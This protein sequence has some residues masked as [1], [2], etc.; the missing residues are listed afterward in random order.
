MSLVMSEY[1]R[2]KFL[3]FLNLTNEEQIPEHIKKAYFK[4]EKTGNSGNI[5]N[6]TTR[7]I[8]FIIQIADL[9]KRLETIESSPNETETKPSKT[10]PSPP[11]TKSK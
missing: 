1:T 9:E 5:S 6:F 10:P 7:E 4:I 8:L 2:K 3:S 11:V